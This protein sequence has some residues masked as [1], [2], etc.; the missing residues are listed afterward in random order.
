M[1]NSICVAPGHRGRGYGSKMI[2]SLFSDYDKVYLE[3]NISN[4][5]GQIFYRKLGFAVH[6]KGTMNYN[7]KEVGLYSLKKG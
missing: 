1:V 6:A 4:Y 3:V 5:E 2:R 7:G